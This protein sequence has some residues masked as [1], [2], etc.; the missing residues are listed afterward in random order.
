MVEMTSYLALLRGINVGGNRIIKMADLKALFVGMGYDAVQ[1][2]IQSGNVVFRAAEEEQP[3]RQRVE[4]QIATT[5]G[6]PVT[7]ILRTAHEMTRLLAA[8]PYA[9]DALAEGESLYVALLAETPSAEGI[10]RLQGTNIAPDESR[11]IGR[12][13][14]LLYRR[15]MRDTRMTNN[16]IEN[17]LGVAATSRNWRVLT[18]L[19][20]LVNE[21]AG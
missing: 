1:T 19:T 16:L 3:L 12:E 4:E 10:A 6:F 2:Y 15:S 17:K 13:A 20:A 11:V 9:P 8:T 21:L 14:Y 18:A 5:F 7:V